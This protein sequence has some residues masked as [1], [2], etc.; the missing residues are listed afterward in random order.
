L[1]RILI[2]L[3]LICNCVFLFAKPEYAGYPYA[4][5]SNDTGFYGGILGYIRYRPAHFDST[6]AKNVFYVSSSY[7]KKKQFNVLIEPTI[8]FKNGLYELHAEM[9]YKKWPS[10]FY[11]IGMGTSRD[12]Y[13]KFTSQELKLNF[14]LTRKLS[15][16]WN[17]SLDY[18]YLDFS[19]VKTKTGGWLAS[20]NFIDN[21][22]FN[23]GIGFTINLDT[24]NSESYPTC[25]GLYSFQL[26]E[27]SHLLGSDYDFTRYTLDLR[28][29]L[30]INPMNTLAFQSFFSGIQNDVPF[31]QLNH[32]NDNMR[33]ITS[34]LYI[35]KH[36]F[37]VRME[38][39]FFYW[40]SG[41]KQRLG[42]VFFAELGEVAPKISKFNLEQTQ[43]NYG[44]GFR[45]SFFLDDRMNAKIDIGFGE[46]KASIS[47]STGEAF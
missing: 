43:F 20:G 16:I 40:N 24:R 38:D 39:R 44:F 42:L 15:T 5:L 29:Y 46:V 14:K 33:A 30:Q 35:D 27:F 31:Y 17:A 6:I 22:E 25:G 19:L 13:E 34:N 28:K 36:A 45:Y 37:T 21:K 7:S 47:I 23:S 18:E 8:R 26:L 2:L 4:G 41:L 1:K 12:I 9:E 32:L 11:G 3:L 10:E